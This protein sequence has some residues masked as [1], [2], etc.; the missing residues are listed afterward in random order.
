MKPG[1]APFEL[2][3]EDLLGSLEQES[4]T[5]P[6][7]GATW[8][9][10]HQVGDGLRYHFPAGTLVDARYLTADLLVDGNRLGVL[11][12]TLQEGEAG[13]SFR[14]LFSALNQCS[15]RMRMPLEAVEQNRWRYERE[16]AWL[17]PMVTGDR[18]DLGRVD[19]AT[20]TVLRKSDRP[21]RWCMTPLTVT[22]AEPPRID[23]PI[24]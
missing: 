21:V 11:M 1:A 24:L 3:P 22:S 16:G 6:I 18:V 13:R 15:A 2:E 14:L 12:L 4:A 7:P 8:Y 23:E 17:K 20:L 5:T 10:A 9:T 19:R